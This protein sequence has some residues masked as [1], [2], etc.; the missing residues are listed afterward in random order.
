MQPAD[1]P[2][3][4]GLYNLRVTPRVDKLQEFQLPPVT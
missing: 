2:L 1:K 4:N 3:E